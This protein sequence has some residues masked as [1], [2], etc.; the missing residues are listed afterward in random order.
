MCIGSM[1][2]SP[3]TYRA[4]Y[5]ESDSE[6]SEALNIAHGAG[7]FRLDDI[8]LTQEQ[9]LDS[10]LS[11]P[12]SGKNANI[13]S[14]KMLGINTGIQASY[15]M[16]SAANLAMSGFMVTAMLLKAED[17]ENRSWVFGWSDGVIEAD[18]I[19]YL[20]NLTEITHLGIESGLL[21]KKLNV[22]E[23]T[24]DTGSYM[25][26]GFYIVNDKCEASDKI[27][28]LCWLGNGSYELGAIHVNNGGFYGI[29]KS[30][31]PD[32]KNFKE[33]YFWRYNLADTFANH[34]L[35]ISTLDV[36]MEVSKRLPKEA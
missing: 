21:N 18:K 13:G 23:V 20:R 9:A 15:G 8:V 2:C 33:G 17:H 28:E 12:E 16:L 3:V 35:A 29:I 10:G 11:G 31:I 22:K 1:G 34:G 26:K 4:Y 32:F 5:Y 27:W 14:A 24:H 30:D 7:L 36:W 19:A 6:K 25:S